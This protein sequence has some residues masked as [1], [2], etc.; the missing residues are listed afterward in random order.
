VPLYRK[1]PPVAFRLAHAVV[2]G[3]SSG[4]GLA[5]A[6]RLAERGA[7]VSLV[8]RGGERLETAAESLRAC[9]AEVYTQAADVADQ[10][11]LVAAL[12]KLVAAGGPCDVLVT[13]AGLARPGRFLELPD[14]VFRQMVEVDYFGTLYALRAV[15]PGMV[16]RGRGSVVAVSSAAGLLGIYGYSAYGPAKF[17]VRGLMESL[18]AE[19]RPHGVH[20]GV[21]YPPDVDTP[22]LAEENVWKPAETRAISGTVR[23]L[24]ADTVARAI[25]DGIDRRRFTICPD[26][27]TRALNRL[28]SVLAPVLH[29]AFDRKAAAAAA[30]VSHD[31]EEFSAS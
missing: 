8:A 10:A 22:Q 19:L 5:T 26:A 29:R 27:A 31:P 2:T 28:G 25:V 6:H 11:A 4:I 20:V 14:D 13:S 16:E 23:P 21:V 1:P 9:G 3:G 7:T 17:A 12:D 30:R 18:R 24:S 15:V